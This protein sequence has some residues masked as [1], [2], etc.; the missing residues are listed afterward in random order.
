MKKLILLAVLFVGMGVQQASA[1]KWLKTLGKVANAALTDDSNKNKTVTPKGAASVPGFTV[2]YT[3]CVASGNDALINFVLTNTTGKEV[4]LW[5]DA[6]HNSC[7]GVDSKGANHDVSFIIGG[8]AVGAYT[9][10]QVP[11]GVPLKCGMLVKDLDRTIKMINSC[12]IKGEVDGTKF[13]WTVPSQ[14]ITT[15]KNTNADNV[16]CTLPDLQFN[17]IKC[18]REGNDVVI[19]ATLKNIGSKD[20]ELFT[21]YDATIYDSEGESYKLNS[22]ACTVGSTHW[23]SYT[24]IQLMKGVPVKVKYVITGVSDSATDFSIVKLPFQCNDREFY[25]EFRNQPILTQ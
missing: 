2:K 14:V 12:T 23:D 22:D 3:G 4:K 7:V 24:K 20:Y 9:T 15:T 17:F 19:T 6:T 11:A 13:V 5:F 1:Q 25:I 21:K 16:V 8:E 10:K 18:V